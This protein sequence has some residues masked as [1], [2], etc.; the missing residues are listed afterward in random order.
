[1]IGAIV[2]MLIVT[3]ICGL[4]S[5]STMA[6][7]WINAWKKP[8]E[9]SINSTLF[10]LAFVFNAV[11]LAQVWAINGSSYDGIYYAGFVIFIPMNLL[12]YRIYQL[13][14]KDSRL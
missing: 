5:G 7:I 6:A 3:T 2:A 10:I 4:I 1:M 11:V 12:T 14:L 8:V 9:I 13:T